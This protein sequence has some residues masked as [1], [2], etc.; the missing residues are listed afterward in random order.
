MPARHPTS[1]SSTARAHYRIDGDDSSGKPAL[2]LLHG[3]GSSLHT[4]DGWVPWLS[5]DL[6][7]IRV[8]LPAFGL[9]GAS[10]SGEYRIADYLRFI[11]AFTRRL[12]L[13]RFHLAGNSL[14]GR[15]AWN[16]ALAAPERVERLVLIAASGYPDTSGPSSSLGFRLAQM[17]VLRSVLPYLTPRALVAR[18]LRDAYGDPQRLSE[19]TIDRYYQLLLRAGN[20]DALVE[21]LKDATRDVDGDPGDITQ[22]TLILWGAEDRWIPLADARG[23]TADIPDAR[24]IVY[25]GVGHLPMEELPGPTARAALVFLTG[26][27]SG[28][29]AA[30]AP[31]NRR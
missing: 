4:W 12:G 25:P 26:D 6:R 18:D 7:V 23:F 14:G 5:H 8:D 13:E 11:D 9:T 10:A 3:T 21:R 2:V 28:E 24:L 22:P 27:D 20:R 17:P 31:R 19:A 29:A 15:I 1:S 16:Y 30:E